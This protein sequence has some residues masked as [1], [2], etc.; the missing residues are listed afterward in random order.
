MIGTESNK[1]SY[2]CRE[3]K[4][5]H[6]GIKLTMAYE[7]NK[8]IEIYH[9]EIEEDINFNAL[10]MFCV[11]NIGPNSESS[12]DEESIQVDYDEFGT[13]VFF[14]FEQKRWLIIAT[15]KASFPVINLAIK[16]LDKSAV[17]FDLKEIEAKEIEEL[18]T[19]H[20]F[21]TTDEEEEV[22]LEDPKL[23]AARR[24]QLSILPDVKLLDN[25]FQKH[26]LYFQPEDVLSGDFYWIKDF[27]KSLYLVVADCTGHSMEGALSTM[28]VSTILNQRIA[29]GKKPQEIIEDIYEDI[30]KSS[31]LQD[32]GYSIGVEL[33]ICRF[34][35]ES[36]QVDIVTSG[37]PVLYIEGEKHHHLLRIKGT[38]DPSY[39][40]LKLDHINLYAEQGHK[41]VLF[42]DGLSDQ[43]DSNDKK[44][45]GNAGVKK[46]FMSMNGNFSFSRF[47]QDLDDWRGATKP[48]DDITVM[49]I[50]M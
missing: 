33:A 45:L 5:K 22:L 38:Q 4:A 49:A 9:N 1:I 43:F 2:I 12:M 47:I 13:L 44:K 20:N 16:D 36:H 30:K 32:E 41:L 23:M 25:Y 3:L 21:V 11:K 29:A 15:D 48:M 10:R 39:K 18:E 19:T 50:E 31:T 17:E 46:M 26:F 27:E 37:V 40:D 34:E 14:R 7:W 8:H 28:T 6:P 35:K 42:T 24:L